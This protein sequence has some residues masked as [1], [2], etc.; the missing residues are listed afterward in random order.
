MRTRPLDSADR[1]IVETLLRDARTS[2]RALG[3]RADLS[4]PVVGDRIRRLEDDGI[5]AAFTLELSAT[6]LGYMT[7]AIVRIEPL[8]GRLAEVESI[9]RDIPEVT[10]CDVVTGD[11]C[12]VVRL[13]LRGL[14][15]LDRVLSPIHRI[16][17]TSTGIVKRSSVK[18][19][20]PPL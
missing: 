15:D 17:R 1:L 16:A 3:S 5:I 11:D 9:L 19:R 10:E 13:A 14:G 12:F 18:R 7:E 20:A 4:A 6:A 8:P 2:L